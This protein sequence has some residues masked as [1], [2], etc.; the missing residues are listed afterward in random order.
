MILQ[1]INPEGLEVIPGN[2]Y[3][4][5]LIN[6]KKRTMRTNRYGIYYDLGKNFP[7]KILLTTVFTNSYILKNRFQYREWIGEQI[8][9]LIT[10]K[11]FLIINY[12]KQEMLLLY[13]RF[14]EK[15]LVLQFRKKY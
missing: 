10:S 3:T 1:D 15:S 13:V 7:F 5:R 12:L 6:K 8:F 11:M 9:R 4:I 14:K 2:V